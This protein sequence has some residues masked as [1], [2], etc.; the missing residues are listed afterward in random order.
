LVTYFDGQDEVVGII[1]YTKI[2]NYDSKKPEFLALL[3]S[4]GGIIPAAKSDIVVEGSLEDR[5][6]KCTQMGLTEKTKKFNDC[7]TLLSK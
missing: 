7:L 1:L 6:K 3:N 5:T 2:E 4:V